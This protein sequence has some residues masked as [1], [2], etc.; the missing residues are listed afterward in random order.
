M[1]ANRHNRGKIR[2][3]LVDPEFCKDV[4]EVAQMGAKKYGRD[5]WFKGQEYTTTLDSLKRHLHAFECG[6]QT[7][8]ESGLHH[9]AHVACNAMFLLYFERHDKYK[10][11]DDRMYANDNRQNDIDETE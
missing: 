6:T 10:I 2:M 3:S 9:L 7:D 8:S 11:F 1:A 5:N 4:A